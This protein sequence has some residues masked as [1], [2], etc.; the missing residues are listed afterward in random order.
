VGEST[1]VCEGVEGE[2]REGYG[3]EK[4]WDDKESS[5]SKGVVCRESPERSGWSL[6]VLL[7]RHEGH[8]RQGDALFR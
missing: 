3:N 7:L 5:N 6:R 8:E 2:D 4:A 1:C